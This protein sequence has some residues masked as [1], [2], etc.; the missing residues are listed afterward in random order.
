[1]VSLDHLG[2]EEIL[3]QSD[4][5]EILAQLEL[6]AIAEPRGRLGQKDQQDQLVREETQ[7]LLVP[8]AHLGTRELRDQLVLLGNQDQLEREAMWEPP[9]VQ[10]QGAIL[11]LLDL[12]DQMGS[13]VNLVRLDLPDNLD[14]EVL[15][16]NQVTLDLEEAMVHRES[17]EGLAQLVS[18]H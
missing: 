5:Q 14:L 7:V 9:A 17:K 10:E 16:V 2:Q 3:V 18:T 11:E 8:V 6:Q 1:M 13:R 4:R 15:L 12:L